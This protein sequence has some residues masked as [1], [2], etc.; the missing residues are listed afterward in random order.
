[1]SR[2]LWAITALPV[3]FVVYAYVLYPLI[4]RGLLLVW[5]SRPLPDGDPETW[6]SVTVI[7]PAHDEEETIRGKLENLLAADYPRDRIDILVVSDASTDR[8]DAIVR[9][10]ASQGVRLLR[11][12]ERSGKIGA[13][14]AAAAEIESELVVN[15]DATT[16]IAR[17]ALKSL[18]RPFQDASVGVASG[19]N[20]SVGRR[21]TQATSG[22]ILYVTWEMWIRSMETALGSIVGASGAL[23]AARRELFLSSFP[24]A[25]SR[26]FGTA[27][28]ARRRGYRAVS[29]P[30]ARCRVPRSDRLDVEFRRKV[31][32]MARGLQT[33]FWFRDL[34]N[35]FRYGFFAFVLASHK[36]ARWI[37]FLTWPI[38]LAALILLS[39]SGGSGAAVWLLV[40][41]GAA[42]AAGLL[43]VG[44]HRRAKKRPS[45]K[46]FPRILGAFSY[47]LVAGLAG[48]VAWW[49]A[50]R[51]SRTPIWE[52]TRRAVLTDE[53]SAEQ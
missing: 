25:M 27:L 42:A 44:W 7:V 38:G 24:T 47:T 26:D 29:V 31:R 28:V 53:E 4:I 9:E 21:D 19:H 32:T 39:L 46:E 20:V 33:L 13:Q 14:N 41:V 40:G 15:T 43:A 22:E 45:G 51:G 50:L 3:A 35:P 52:P 49:E 34:L 16:R 48:M 11:L 23:F 1:M 17:E 10:F 12:E 8:T 18:I 5:R 2:L 30:G 37:V 6:P 36:L